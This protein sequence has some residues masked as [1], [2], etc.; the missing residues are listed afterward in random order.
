MKKKVKLIFENNDPKKPFLISEDRIPPTDKFMMFGIGKKAIVGE[1]DDFIGAPIKWVNRIVA[2]PEQIGLHFV[3]GMLHHDHAFPDGENTLEEIH[4]DTLMEISLKKKGICF[5]EARFSHTECN[6]YGGKHLDKKCNC[7]SG[8][9]GDAYKP[10][11]V[12]GK[13]IIYSK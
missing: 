11:L 12:N 6:N 9:I 10:L 13:V 4:P 3:S 5:I 1:F 8:K 2:T 7:Q